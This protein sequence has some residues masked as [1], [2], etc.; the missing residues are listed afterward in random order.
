MLCGRWIIRNCSGIKWFFFLFFIH[1]TQIHVRNTWCIKIMD[2]DFF[3]NVS[4]SY[5]VSADACDWAQVHLQTDMQFGLVSFGDSV[6]PC[7]F[8]LC[9]V[10]TADPSN[11]RNPTSSPFSFKEVLFELIR[12]AA[13]YVV[14]V[15]VAITLTESGHTTSAICSSFLYRFSPLVHHCGWTTKESRFDS[16]LRQDIFLFFSKHPS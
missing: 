11:I 15:F 2:I 16:C 14:L 3:I 7:S 9:F 10:I 1:I 4:Y 8:S 12:M 5:V 13:N 6:E